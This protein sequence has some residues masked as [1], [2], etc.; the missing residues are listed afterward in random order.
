[1]PM[2]DAMADRH[3]SKRWRQWQIGMILRGGGVLVS[4]R[5]TDGH[6]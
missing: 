2:A 3:D 5:L 1:M 4:D 6:L